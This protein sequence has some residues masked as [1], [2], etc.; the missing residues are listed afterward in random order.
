MKKRSLSWLAILLIAALLVGCGAPETPET[1][2]TEPTEA[3]TQAP[4]PT[5]AATEDATEP[6]TEAD[7]NDVCDASAYLAN[8]AYAPQVERYY[9]ALTQ[10][11]DQ[12]Q[13]FDNDMS[14]LPVH[15]YEGDPLDNVGFGFQDLDNDG[16]E[17]L[18]I[19]AVLNAET[20]PTVFEIWTLVDD[21]P[22]MLAQGGSGNRYVLQFVEED[23]MWYVTQEASNGA[24][25]HATYYMMLMDG[26]LEVMQGIVF[27]AEADAENPWFMT[28]DMDWDVSNDDPIDEDTA[29]AILESNRSHYKAV[30][31]FPYSLCR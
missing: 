17:E 19:G 30:E 27:D 10:K 25:N 16:S 8:P 4:D 7:T 31:Y 22:V 2:P 11:W 18:I 13:Y 23:N 6:T 5:E 3:E 14:A 28:Y 26:K 24:A 1:T 21:Q 29:N 20:D 9:T 12:E 15:Y